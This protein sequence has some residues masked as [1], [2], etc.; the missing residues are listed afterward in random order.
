MYINLLNFSYVDTLGRCGDNADISNSRNFMTHIPLHIHQ[1]TI[2]KKL[3]LSSGGL[4]FHEI[5]IDGIT[6]DHVNYHLKEL[7]RRKLVEKDKKI[8]RLTDLGKDHSGSL[9]DEMRLL[10]KQP[11]V[12]VIVW[13]TRKRKDGVNEYLVNRRTRQPY[14]GKVGRITGKVRYGEALADAALRELKEET[15][16]TADFIQLDSVYHKIRRRPDGVTV[17]D[18]IFFIFFLSKI[19]GKLI[20]KVDFQENFWVTVQDVVEKRYD[21]YDDFV[22]DDRDKPHPHVEYSE[23]IATAD[24][25]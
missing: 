19:R 25:Y 22:I 21:F 6:S 11:K 1:L 7:I 23:S 14:F 24:G 13:A 5:L 3:T 8:Y 2:L 4:A 12:S 17:Q 10:E 20:P 15:G 16:L 9:D 18:I